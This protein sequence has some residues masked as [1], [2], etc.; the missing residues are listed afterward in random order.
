MRGMHAHLLTCV[1]V[2]CNPPV[3]SV[4][5]GKSAREDCHF[6]LQGTFLTLGL[7]LSL[8]RLQ[9]MQADSLPLSRLGSLKTRLLLLLSCSAVSDSLQPMDCS[10]PGFPVLDYLPEFPQT[11]QCFYPSP[12]KKRFCS[13]HSCHISKT[14]YFLVLSIW[15]VYQGQISGEF[16]IP[17]YAS[18]FLFQNLFEQICNW[19]SVPL[20][21]RNHRILEFCISDAISPKDWPPRSWALAS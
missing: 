20:N 4:H 12:F 7:N 21:K 1:P 18:C 15:N 11:C 19:N 2:D 13:I 10:T 16:F 8:L 6:L 14:L 3:S 5:P 17:W 9:H